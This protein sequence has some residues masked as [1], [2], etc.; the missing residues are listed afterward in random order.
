MCVPVQVRARAGSVCNT[1]QAVWRTV[2]VYCLNITRL[3]RVIALL[4]RFL[5]PFV[6]ACDFYLRTNCSCSLSLFFLLQIGRLF[7]CVISCHCQRLFSFYCNKYQTCSSV[8]V[9]VH[10]ANKLIRTNGVQYCGSG[11]C[12]YANVSVC[13][14]C[15]VN[16]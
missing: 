4:F 11:T 9:S 7:L 16:T 6:V 8:V 12:S 10:A 13:K 14:N 5:L 1:L 2:I 3:F 15:R